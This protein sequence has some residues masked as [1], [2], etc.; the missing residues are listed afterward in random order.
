TDSVYHYTS[1]NGVTWYRVFIQ[2]GLCAGDYAGIAKVSAD[3]PTV[4]GVISGDAVVCNGNN[5]GKIVLTGRTGSLL[6]WEMSSDQGNTWQLLP[7]NADTLVYQNLLQTTLYRALVKNGTCAMV[8]TNTLQITVVEPVTIADAGADQLLCNTSNI[9]VMNANTPLSGSGIWS[10]VS[11]PSTVR[12]SNAALP[13]AEV[14]GLQNGSYYFVWTISN[15]TCANSTDTVKLTLDKVVSDFKV[16]SVNECGIS[17][18]HFVNTSHSAFGIQNSVWNSG[19]GDTLL[20]KDLDLSFTKEGPQ[21]MKLTV[22]SESGCSHS[23]DAIYKVLVYAF[24]RANINA[25]AD[26]CKSQMLKVTSDI[27]SKDSIAYL[28]WN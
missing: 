26:I 1:L 21:H 23:I 4:A 15:G 19:N 8:Y 2:S 5:S 11:G 28:L 6:H 22:T 24:P 18:Y 25:I 16:S 27:S 7:A 12:F 14:T 9:A 17:H 3:L 20:N 10:Q 13:N